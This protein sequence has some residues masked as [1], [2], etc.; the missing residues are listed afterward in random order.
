MKID[1]NK[2]EEMCV[3]I[4]EREAKTSRAERDSIKFKQAEYLLEKI[5]TQFEGIVSGVT[6]WGLYIELIDNKCEGMIRYNSLDGVWSV[7]TKLHKITNGKETIRL[8]DSITIMVKAVDIEK[9]QVDFV[10]I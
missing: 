7:D 4:S 5:G 9:K 10:K 3:H 1:R 8:G 6:D 2:L